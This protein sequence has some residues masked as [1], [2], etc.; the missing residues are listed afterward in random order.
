[1]LRA[2]AGC[3]S[4]GGPTS[5][6]GCRSTRGGSRKAICSS[7]SAAE[8]SYNNE[9]GVPLTLCRIEPE[10]ELVILELAMRGFGQIAAL[11]DV[12]RPHV[13][14]ITM[15]A[16]VHLEKVGSLEGVVRAKSELIDA[17]PGGGTAVVP[18]G[19]PVERDDLHVVRV[20]E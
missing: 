9:I 6:P 15:I 19:F 17:L 5:S 2:W 4:P 1:M 7:R 10:T 12:A 18:A 14:V 16:P 20:G 8:R 11:C 3:R 13:G